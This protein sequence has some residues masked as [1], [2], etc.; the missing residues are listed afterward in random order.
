[1]AHPKAGDHDKFGKELV[2]AAAN[3]YHVLLASKGMFLNP[4]NKLKLIKK[5]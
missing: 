5:A 4:S 1:M 2:L 3:I